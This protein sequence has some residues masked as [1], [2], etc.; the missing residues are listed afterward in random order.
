MVYKISDS[1]YDLL[2]NT[3]INTTSYT[4]WFYF[5]VTRNK[6]EGPPLPATLRIVN[7]MKSTSLYTKG[8]KVL[9]CSSL[10]NQWKRGGNSIT[11]S[12]NSF[13]LQ[14]NSNKTYNTLSFEYVFEPG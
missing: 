8:M 4:Q 13:M 2:L 5:K 6:L 3:D 12:R 11:Y 9:L 10:E 14:P 7:L 1:Q